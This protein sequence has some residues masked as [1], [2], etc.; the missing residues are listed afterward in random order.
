MN[1]DLTEKVNFKIIRYANCWEDADILLEGLSPNEGSKILSIGSAGDNS[2][3]LITTNPEIVVAVDI[4]KIQLYLIELKKACIKKLA[5]EEALAFMGFEPCS[6]RTYFFNQIK[7]EMNADARSYWEANI[8]L[9]NNGIIYTGK[10]EKYFLMF[11]KIVLPW[12]HSKKT[13]AE[14]FRT[15]SKKKQEIF[16]VEKWNTWRWK[17]LF[18][19]FFSKYVMGKYGRDPQFLKEVKLSVA[20]YIYCKAGVH[21]QSVEAQKNFM[22]HFAL[23]GNFGNFLPHYM[24][25][26]NYDRIKSNIDNLKLKEGYTREAVNHFGKFKYMN[27]SNIFEYMDRQLF[28]TT[29]QELIKGTDKDGNL[30]YW[31]LM[32]D[33]RMSEI[34]PEKIKYEKALSQRLTEKDKGFFYNQ[35]I[36]D[37]I[38]E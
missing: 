2:F 33:R 37:K 4:N 6:K 12:I 22:L 20:D 38:N 9:I 27:L 21:L 1:E 29:A 32:V 26:E 34:F 28:A 16:Y 11:S 14:L 8:N 35:I 18:K 15:K 17:L 3:S 31:N 10:F 23:K 5:H 13:V 19:I 24:R 30:A 36:I 7:K 25:K